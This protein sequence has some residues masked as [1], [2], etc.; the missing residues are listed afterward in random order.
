MFLGSL[1]MCKIFL[2]ISNYP[3]HIAVTIRSIQII[4]IMSSVYISN[5]AIKR[6]DCIKCL[7]N[8]CTDSDV[9]QNKNSA[10]KTIN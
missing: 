1:N 8:V 3:S 9:P 5:V 4:V 2:K 10:Y 7:L 6:A